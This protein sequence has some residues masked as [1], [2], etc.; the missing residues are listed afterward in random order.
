MCGCKAKIVSEDS[1]P[2][3]YVPIPLKAVLSDNFNAVLINAFCMN[4]QK[5][6]DAFK[7]ATGEDIEEKD[8]EDLVKV[9]Q[10]GND[11]KEYKR[12]FLYLVKAIQFTD[13]ERNKP[14]CPF[15][16]TV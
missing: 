4:P 11:V 9:H 16:Y 8:L 10:A 3:G 15:V 13:A 14:S 1:V 2:Q 5:V 7:E 6:K 12:N